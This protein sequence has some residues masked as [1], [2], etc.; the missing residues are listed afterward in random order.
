MSKIRVGFYGTGRFANKTHIP[1]LLKL[2]DVEIVALCDADP[3]ALAAT[4]ARLPAARPYHD[5]HEMLHNERLDALYSCVPAYARADVEIA[6]VERGIHLFSEKPQ[7]L[8]LKLACA[9][10]RAIQQAGVIS[11]VG[12]RERYR[13]MFEQARRFLADKRVAHVQFTSLR[14]LPQL[15]GQERSWYD[16]LAKSGGP[17]LDWGVH[18]TD[19]ARYMTGQD[20]QS[21]QAFYHQPQA[22]AVPVSSSFHYQLTHGATMTMTFVSALSP[23]QPTGGTSFIILYE[24]GRLDVYLYDGLKVNGEWFLQGEPFDPW[25]EQDRLFIEAIR[26]GDAGLLRNDYHDGLYSLGPVLAGWESA[27]RGGATLHFEEYLREQSRAS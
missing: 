16:D 1:N 15:K 6:A 5:A 9:I 19:Y 12:F 21:V 23:G 13:P 22:Y 2:G 8:D 17:A 20:I 7:A 25:F 3:T 14:A 24:G 27:R 11:T 26:T 4:A 18:A 10:D